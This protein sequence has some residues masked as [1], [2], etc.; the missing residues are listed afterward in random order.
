[1]DY[2]CSD[3]KSSWT[4]FRIFITYRGSRLD[5]WKGEFEVATKLD[6]LVD[7]N[8]SN[9]NRYFRN[10]DS[11]FLEKREEQRVRFNS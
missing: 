11:T 5:N 4:S 9:T 3:G 6:I 2:F 8:S 7:V 1:M 10:C